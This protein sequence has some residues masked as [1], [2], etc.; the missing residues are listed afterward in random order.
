MGARLGQPSGGPAA[1]L[2]AWPSFLGVEA[3]Y[4][5]F[6]NFAR[7]RVERLCILLHPQALEHVFLLPLQIHYKDKYAVA[8]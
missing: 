8:A 1:A 2:T 3:Q 5:R 4:L 6:P 7:T